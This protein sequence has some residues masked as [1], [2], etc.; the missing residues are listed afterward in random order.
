MWAVG[1]VV[2]SG[3]RSQAVDLALQFTAC[4]LARAGTSVGSGGAAQGGGHERV[5]RLGC[6]QLH[7]VDSFVAVV[8]GTENKKARVLV[9]PG[10]G[11]GGVPL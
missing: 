6:C 2:D 8:D 10:P 9:L 3:A 11:V 1:R 7:G 4:D 5:A